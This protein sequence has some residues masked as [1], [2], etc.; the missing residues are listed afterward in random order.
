MSSSITGR[1]ETSADLKLGQQVAS[2]TKTPVINPSAPDEADLIPT[3]GLFEETADSADTAASKILVAE[4]DST[5]DA[6]ASGTAEQPDGEFHSYTAKIF[7][8][9]AETLKDTHEKVNYPIVQKIRK[10]AAAVIG[11]V[12]MILAFVLVDSVRRL[13]YEFGLNNGMAPTSWAGGFE[14]LQPTRQKLRSAIEGIAEAF[15]KAGQAIDAGKLNDV[16]FNHILNQAHDNAANVV[17]TVLAKLEPEKVPEFL[18]NFRSALIQSFGDDDAH[19]PIR[20][21]STRAVLKVDL[22]MHEIGLRVRSELV[23]ATATAIAEQQTGIGD[24]QVK[25]EFLK[26]VEDTGIVSSGSGSDDFAGDVD[27]VLP[28]AKQDVETKKKAAEERR[29]LE[30]QRKKEETERQQEVERQRQEAAQKL[31]ERRRADEAAAQKLKQISDIGS[32]YDQA[33]GIMT[34]MTALQGQILT[35]YQAINTNL[36]SREE[37]VGQYKGLKDTAVNFITDE[38]AVDGTTREVAAGQAMN[39][40]I[41]LM[42]ASDQAF[43]DLQDDLSKAVAPVRAVRRTIV[44]ESVVRTGI[45]QIERLNTELARLAEQLQATRFPDQT[46]V[47]KLNDAGINGKVQACMTLQSTIGTNALKLQEAQTSTFGADGTQGRNGALKARIASELSVPVPKKAQAK[48]P[49]DGLEVDDEEPVTISTDRLDVEEEAE[50]PTDGL[51]VE[52]DAVITTDGLD[53]EEEAEISTDGLVVDEDDA[54][55][56]L[57]NGTPSQSTTAQPQ[58]KTVHRYWFNPMRIVKGSTYE[59]AAS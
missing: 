21:D 51:T 45:Q 34:Q 47:Q 35:Q 46:I 17:R 19:Y 15:T 7:N 57:F 27:A 52:D 18:A 38:Y 1:L 39:A 14:W 11:V 56:Q 33:A 32:T 48:I 30:E 3:T 13:G 28:K 5:T 25:N 9:T 55:T 44:D 59:V 12:G 26:K 10:L 36:A 50:I 4:E 37:L 41:D 20:G 23:Q 49:T 40:M 2:S 58:K 24:D 29:Q 42:A 22:A 54:A 6:S 53:V 43:N 31:E 16:K 8:W